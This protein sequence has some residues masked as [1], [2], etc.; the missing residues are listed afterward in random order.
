MEKKTKEINALT[1]IYDLIK[2]IIPVLEKF[3]RSQKF[4]LAD[5]IEVLLL[6]IM[7]MIIQSVYTRDKEKFLREANIK[8][9]KLR[10]L[11]RLV[12]DMK[13]VSTKKYEYI[14]SALHEIGCEI[15]GWLKYAKSNKRHN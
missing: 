10:Y 2:W 1:R 5:R 9:E 6:D 14:I 8:I 3:P 12:H 7:E 4:L 15:G 13:Y 11:V